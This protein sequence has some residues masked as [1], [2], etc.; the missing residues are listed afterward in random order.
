MQQV[1]RGCVAPS[2]R[3]AVP[4]ARVKRAGQEEPAACHTPLLRLAPHGL[5]AEDPTAPCKGRS[6]L[7]PAIRLLWVTRPPTRLRNLSDLPNVPAFEG[8]KKKKTITANCS[9]LVC[10]PAL[11]SS[12]LLDAWRGEHRKQALRS[13]PDAAGSLPGSGLRVPERQGRCVMACAA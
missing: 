10:D 5:L 4:A 6:Q 7:F 9:S 1:Q 3:P 2:S 12:K 11:A 13:R 8:E